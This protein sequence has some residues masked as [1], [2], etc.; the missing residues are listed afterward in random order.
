MYD[1]QTVTLILSRDK[2]VD[3]F[4]QI[5]GEGSPKGSAWVPSRLL[6]WKTDDEKKFLDLCLI[7]EMT[8]LHKD[9]CYALVDQ[10]GDRLESIGIELY[11]R[12]ENGEHDFCSLE[13]AKKISDLCCEVYNTNPDDLPDL[14][15]KIEEFIFQREDK[16]F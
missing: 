1:V 10:D 13:F 15:C 5:F 3:L 2:L 12:L 6:S 7:A 16:L 14:A 9:L 11:E 8:G 4:L